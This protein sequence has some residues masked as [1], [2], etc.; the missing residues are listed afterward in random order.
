MPTHKR[1]L[2]VT[3][4]QQWSSGETLEQYKAAGKP[5]NPLYN[6]GG[7][8]GGGNAYG[9]SNTN[10]GKNTNGGEGVDYRDR[11]LE[12]LT[13][14]LDIVKGRKSWQEIYKEESERLDISGQQK[15]VSGIRGEVLDMEGLLDKLESDIES[16]TKGLLV[17][18]AQER[19]Q[20]A[21][22]KRPLRE[23]LTGLMRAEERARIGLSGSRA[24][25]ANIMGLE[26]KERA[27]QKE[28]AFGMLPYYKEAYGETTEEAFARMMKE[29]EAKLELKGKYDTPTTAETES[30]ET[31]RV[32]DLLTNS[33][34]AY[35]PAAGVKGRDHV[36]GGYYA[37]VRS[38]STLGTTEFD[39]RFSYLLSDEDKISLGL[40]KWA[41]GTDEK[42][43]WKDF[44]SSEKQ[45]IYNW[46]AKLPGF[47]S[48]DFKKMNEDS[49]FAAAIIAEYY[50]Q[51]TG[52]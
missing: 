45:S 11:V 5:V 15:V 17:T 24:E 10:G 31:K 6:T 29:E 37:Q 38:Q 8:S 26:E 34:E 20:L 32:K 19:R 50:K 21:T 43:V 2:W 40:A 30:K 1:H 16:R 33:G 36:S 7:G 14:Y 25:L 23:E 46:M 9:D 51:Y 42:S 39:R 52:W 4:G 48:S 18:G 49:A 44:T 27:S 35:N 47:S 12:A 28:K 41:G 13:D 3:P 22:E